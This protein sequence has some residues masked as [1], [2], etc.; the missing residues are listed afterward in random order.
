[1]RALGRYLIKTD[2][3]PSTI[4]CSSAYRARETATNLTEELG[5]VEKGISFVDDLY[6]AS[7]REFL[8]EIGKVALDSRE[9][10]M[11]GHNP[12]ITYVSEYLT[13][14]SIGIMDP[15]GLTSILFENMNW[16]DLDQTSGKF[17]AY[18][19]PNQSDVQS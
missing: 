19:H 5:I 8:L 15:C 1:M 2:F 17:L 13:G 3:N 6:S 7:V 11:V 12:T 18:Y 14:E 4:L 9:I 16:A 10:L